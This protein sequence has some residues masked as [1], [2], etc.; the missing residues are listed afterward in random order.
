MVY[1]YFFPTVSLA[2]ANFSMI[3]ENMLMHMYKLGKG[4]W[5]Q[6]W[7]LGAFLD[8][9]PAHFDT[10][11]FREY[12]THWLTSAGWA[13]SCCPGCRWVL[14]VRTQVFMPAGSSLA[15][16]LPYPLLNFLFPQNYKFTC[17][18]P[19]DRMF[20]WVLLQFSR[21]QHGKLVQ[22]HPQDPGRGTGRQRLCHHGLFLFIC[23]YVFCSF[24]LSDDFP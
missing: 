12:W 10:G 4:L 24:S 15:E 21:W 14:D 5:E 20:Q 1:K 16:P 11:S 23:D 2:V 18:Y 3:E 9:P 17:S 13:V 6:R 7:T 19:K 22:Y 8:H